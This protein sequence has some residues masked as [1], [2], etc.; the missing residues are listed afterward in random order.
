MALPEE[1]IEFKL[2]TKIVYRIGA[3][4]ELPFELGELGCKRPAIFTDRGVVE[5]GILDYVKEALEGSDIDIAGVF[6]GV[7]Q[8]AL[9]SVINEAARFV[10][11]TK[12]DGIVAVGGGSVMDTAKGANVL[13][14]GGEE[15][16]AEHVG[17]ELVGRPMLPH[18]AI[19]TTS[20][21]GCEVTWGA[22]IKNEEERTKTGFIEWYCVADVALLDPKVTVSLPPALTAST[23][24]DAL[25]HAIE[26]YTS[27]YANPLADAMT[28]HAVRL[29]SRWLRRAVEKGDDLEARAYMQF[30]ATV[31]GV[32]FFNTMCGAVHACAHALG[33]MFDVPHGVANS[34]MLPAVM[35]YN[36]DYV[37]E[38]YRDV[39]EAMGV[40]VRG[41]SAVEAADA[42]IAEVR[43]LIRDVGLPTDLKGYGIREEDLP[44][45]AVKAMEDIQMT[46]NPRPADEEE[47]AELFRRLL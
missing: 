47:I 28:L 23:G 8:D 27:P 9:V 11:E 30:A 37:A 20:G 42:A 36:R 45:L 34:I 38:R 4:E 29:V 25:T 40:V 35:E 19:P 18:V 31:A 16:I 26:A 10:R 21:T 6:D 2:R 15:D 24:I 7:R 1:L 5:A 32:G 33:G 13:V 39:A 46:F 14:T 22:I 3:V 44:E 41:L 12:A 17:A 43:K